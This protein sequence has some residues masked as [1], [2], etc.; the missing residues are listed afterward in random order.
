MGVCTGAGWA[1]FGGFRATVFSV[2]GL[3]VSFAGSGWY[4]YV[5]LME[6]RVPPTPV[7]PQIITGRAEPVVSPPKEVAMMLRQR[8]SPT[9]NMRT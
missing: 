8:T 9:A 1:L 3:L 5:K 7:K 2:S 4:S 6:K